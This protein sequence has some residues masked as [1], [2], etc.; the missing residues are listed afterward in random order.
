MGSFFACFL[1]FDTS[2]QADKH[3]IFSISPLVNFEINQQSRKSYTHYSILHQLR[4]AFIPLSNNSH[5]DAH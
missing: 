2:K 4:M 5:I 1:L 3:Y